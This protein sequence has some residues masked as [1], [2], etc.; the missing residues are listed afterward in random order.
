MTK[1]F[2]FTRKLSTSEILNCGA[3]RI[4]AIEDYHAS[5]FST[6]TF[7]GNADGS[8]SVNPNTLYLGWELEVERK[9]SDYSPAVAAA[10]VRWTAKQSG[11]VVRNIERDG[12][13]SNGFEIISQPATL[14]YHMRKAG[15]ADILGFLSDAGY[16]SHDTGSCGLHVHVSE[17][18]LG[19]TPEARDRVKALIVLLVDRFYGAESSMP[20]VKFARRSPNHYC[21]KNNAGIRRGDNRETI[22]AKAKAT[23]RGCDRYRAVNLT[24]AATVEFRLFKG[25]LNAETFAAT[26]QLVDTLVRWAMNHTVLEA[27]SCTFGDI[28]AACKY[29]ELKSYCERRGIDIRTSSEVAATAANSR[30]E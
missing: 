2:D 17:S 11:E 16:A 15:L 21:S 18:A 3:S 12:S 28:V 25:T 8:V 27:L 5:H 24:N 22:V 23:S 7:L 10:F 20:L 19:R 4:G 9:N 26:L 30:E 1:K 13:L 29:P 14:A 6:P